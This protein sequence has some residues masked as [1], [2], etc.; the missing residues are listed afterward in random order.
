[1]KNYKLRESVQGSTKHM[2]TPVS[3]NEQFLMRS[4]GPIQKVRQNIFLSPTNMGNISQKEI[5]SP[6]SQNAGF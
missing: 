2:K 1:M 4:F 3:M 5:W 6:N